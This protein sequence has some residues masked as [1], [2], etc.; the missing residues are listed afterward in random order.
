MTNYFKMTIINFMFY[1]NDNGNG[2]DNDNDMVMNRSS[3]FLFS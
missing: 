3:A 1:D 2:Y